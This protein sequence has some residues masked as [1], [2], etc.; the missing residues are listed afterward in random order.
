MP[1]L[2]LHL[3]IRLALQTPP[4]LFFFFSLSRVS[5]RLP[6]S[7]FSCVQEECREVW[8]SRSLSEAFE[9]VLSLS[10]LILLSLQDV[11]RWLNSSFAVSRAKKGQFISISFRPVVDSSIFSKESGCPALSSP[12]LVLSSSLSLCSFFSHP[13]RTISGEGGFP[14]LSSVALRGVLED[15][16]LLFDVVLCVCQPFCCRDGCTP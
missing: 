13:R 15:S 9:G 2:V 6:L 3:E 5:M 11:S 4:C 7:S 12:P 14:S 10:R 8:I 16:F 1:P